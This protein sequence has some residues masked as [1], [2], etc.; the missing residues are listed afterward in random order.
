MEVFLQFILR[1]F[2]FAKSHLF[3]ISKADL[4]NLLIIVSFL[5]GCSTTLPILKKQT[6]L[7]SKPLAPY[8]AKGRVF[9]KVD[10][11]KISGS[12]ELMIV[13]GQMLFRAIRPVLGDTIYE[14]HADSERLMIIDFSEEKYLL[15]QNTREV[16]RKFLGVDIE[17]QEL[18][19]LLHGQIESKYFTSHGGKQSSND[20]FELSWNDV[21]L[22]LNTTQEMLQYMK[23]YSQG[24]L[25]Y[26]A[27]INQY[28][29]FSGRKYP[30]LVD[31]Q[32]PN[33]NRM[34]LA[35]T[36]ISSESLPFPD[37]LPPPDISEKILLSSEL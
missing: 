24:D 1:S 15:T 13:K 8:F 23:K 26:S 33:K 9:L 19:W 6:F 31:I 34:R 37:F 18:F 4:K 7:S 5:V 3:Q 16:R 2:S 36:E 35:I 28:Q 30:T 10:Q 21:L 32:Q 29:N 25:M 14:V 12:F 11:R 22:H 17:I 20:L 27:T